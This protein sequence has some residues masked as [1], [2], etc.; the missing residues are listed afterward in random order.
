M[1]S[2]PLPTD[3]IVKKDPA[4]VS[5]PSSVDIVNVE[6]DVSSPESVGDVN[7]AVVQNQV[8]PQPEDQLNSQCQPKTSIN[9]MTTILTN[10]KRIMNRY[11][12]ELSQTY[13][14]A[15]NKDLKDFNLKGKL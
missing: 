10:K 8:D 12:D 14:Q 3:E 9:N 7:L 11:F 2:N 5:S 15:H 13:A 1:K 6:R 4:C